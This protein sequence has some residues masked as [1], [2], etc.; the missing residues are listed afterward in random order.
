MCRFALY[1]GTPIQISALVTDSSHSIVH[2]SYHALEREEPLN[3]DGFGIAWYAPEIS[4]TP[5]LYKDISPAWNNRNLHGLA[6][7]IKSPCILAHVRAAT[8]GT[9]VNYANCHPFTRNNYAF[10]HNGVI[11]GFANIKRELRRKL[12]DFS[13][14]SIEGSTD[15]E[16]AF[17]LVMDHLVETQ[18]KD[19][20]IGQAMGQAIRQTIADIRRLQSAAG[21]TKPSLLNFVL[22]DGNNAV[23]SRYTSGAP[24]KANT[25]Y[26]WRGKHD[27]SED[28]TCRFQDSNNSVNND[29][30]NALIVASEPLTRDNNWIAVAPNELVIV[31]DMYNISLEKILLD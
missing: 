26:Y 18:S 27:I 16:H 7:V 19:I 6:K 14:S 4:S 3:G 17:A 21:E 9:A 23:I 12:S 31:T 1:M 24:E 8:G 15:S 25:L 11:G 29:G 22:S 2:Q 5:G 28:G 10:M 20:P 13:Y 30:D